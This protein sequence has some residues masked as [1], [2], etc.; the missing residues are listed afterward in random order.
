MIQEKEIRFRDIVDVP[1][2]MLVENE[3]YLTGPLPDVVLQ[4][5][6]IDGRIPDTTMT[7]NLKPGYT[8]IYMNWSWYIEYTFNGRNDRTAPVSGR[9]NGTTTFPINFGGNPQG[10][11]WRGEFSGVFR[12]PDGWQGPGSGLTLISSIRGTNPS[13]AEIRARL[14]S[15]PAQVR[16]YKESRFRQF[17]ADELPLFGSPRGF[18]VMQIDTPPATA[19]QVWSWMDNV[20]GG[21]A[22][23]AA[24]SREVAQH[25]KNIYASD[26]TIPK[27]TADQMRLAEYQ[28]YNGGWYWGWNTASRSWEKITPEPYA[29]DAVRIEESVNAGNLP[30]D[31]T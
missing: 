7:L 6:G 12:A 22:L 29:D 13:K 3:C 16:A 10:G 18:G 25:Y 19:R 23:I 20:D 8:A 30:G 21:L 26:P 28:W 24:K 1:D 2:T 14:G 9:V 31:W 27:L 5:V 15:V 4:R 17:G 11:L